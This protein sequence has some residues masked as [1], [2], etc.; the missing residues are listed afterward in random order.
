MFGTAAWAAPILAA[1]EVVLGICI[2]ILL[3]TRDS[4]THVSEYADPQ[5]KEGNKV[6]NPLR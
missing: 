5:L 6:G 2:L 4:Y 3:F 1:Q